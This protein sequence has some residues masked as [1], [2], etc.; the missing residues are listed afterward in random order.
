ML[1]NQPLRAASPAIAPGSCSRNPAGREGPDA[2]SLLE[3]SRKSAQGSYARQGPQD[4]A[5]RALSRGGA[6]TSGVGRSE[7]RQA[8]AS[9]R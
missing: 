8:A 6:A 5:E 2:S 9:H 4:R 7:E 1:L 3:A